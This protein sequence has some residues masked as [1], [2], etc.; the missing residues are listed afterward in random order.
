MIAV[1]IHPAGTWILAPNRGHNSVAVFEV[2]ASTGR[3]SRTHIQPLESLAGSG[4][5]ALDS[6]GQTCY[7]GGKDCLQEYF[8]DVTQGR[9]TLSGRHATPEDEAAGH[10]VPV[11]LPGEE[12]VARM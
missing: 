10:I 7:V 9:L 4:P 11:D 1:A 8:L 12:L 3:L 2:E 5:L 6:T